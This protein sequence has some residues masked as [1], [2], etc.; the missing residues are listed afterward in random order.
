MR[1]ADPHFRRPVIDVFWR[2]QARAVLAVI[3]LAITGMSR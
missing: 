1:K 2:K 3:L